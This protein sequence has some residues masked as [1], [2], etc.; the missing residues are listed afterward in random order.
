MFKI[1]YDSRTILALVTTLSFWAS[2]FAGIRAALASYQPGH[3]ALL[4][5][6]VAS[7]CL[8]VYALITRTPLPER[9][10]IPFIALLGFL[11]Y[12]VYHLGVAYGEVTV[13]AGPP[14]C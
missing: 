14:A 7:A 5:F 13:T 3:L 12:T 4:R 1:R 10:D 8:G 2:S 9:R 6:L 11:G